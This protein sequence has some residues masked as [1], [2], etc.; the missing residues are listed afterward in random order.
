MKIS[1]ESC[2]RVKR[3]LL[4]CVLFP[5]VCTIPFPELEWFR[6]LYYVIP[7]SGIATYVLLLNFPCI[8][9]KV[10]SRPLYFNDLEDNRDIEPSTQK[11]FQ[12]IFV[13]ILQITLT[14]LVAGLV[15]YYY[16]QFHSTGLS[17]MEIFG[18]IG[19]FVS[20]ML[21]IENVVGKFALTIVGLCKD[22]AIATNRL[23]SSSLE[24]IVNV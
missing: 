2:R 8:V 5:F 15:Y 6:S 21:K 9:E 4:I 23:R 7:A 12:M 10:H 14:L 3:A 13:C 16:D 24:Y 22:R 11:R 17:K 19:G 18:V 20:L 1:K